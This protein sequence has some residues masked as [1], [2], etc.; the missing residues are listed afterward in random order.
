MEVKQFML[1][2]INVINYCQNWSS[3][4]TT[5]IVILGVGEEAGVEDVDAV[6]EG[7]VGVAGV[8]D[9]NHF[10]FHVIQSH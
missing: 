4:R 1:A 10:L 3:Q 9:T 8:T 5:P 7:G 6:V 2:V